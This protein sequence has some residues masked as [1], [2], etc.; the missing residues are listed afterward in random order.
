MA[1]QPEI[2]QNDI[3]SGLYKENPFLAK[4]IN[5]DQYVLEGKVVHIPQAGTGSNVAKNR[6][7]LPA[8]VNER[9]DTEVT[10]VLDEYTSDPVLIRNIDTV[11]LSYSKR[12][13]VMLEDQAKLNEKVADGVLSKWTANVGAGQILRTTGDLATTTATG[14]TG[15]RRL[16]RKEDLLKAKTKLDNQKVPAAG[17]V[18][19]I[20]PEFAETLINDKDLSVNFEKYADLANGVIGRLHGFDI[21]VR[22]E[23]VRFTNDTTPAPKDSDAASAATDNTAALCWHPFA[24]ERALGTVKMFE[25]IDDPQFFGSVYSFLLMM[26]GRARRAD[27]K[28][29]VAIVEAAS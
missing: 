14:A 29:L 20:S 5:A 21:M 8:T 6:A 26:G 9:T 23:P 11:Q 15:Q 3:V 18:A 10:Y 4:A 7:S 12:E 2:W 16:F 1:L 17:R 13:S 28:G 19:L 24:V 25:K 22:P 27:A